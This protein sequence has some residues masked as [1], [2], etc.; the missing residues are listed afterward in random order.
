M[1]CCC[2][3]E[4]ALVDGT[5]ELINTEVGSFT[6]LLRSASTGGVPP[7]RGS[8]KAAT[9]ITTGVARVSDGA[10]SCRGVDRVGAGTVN[11]WFLLRHN[12]AN[13]GLFAGGALRGQPGR[14]VAALGKTLVSTPLTV[15]AASVACD[16]S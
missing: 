6:I 16:E 11:G 1:R 4:I 14:L 9:A 3:I 15:S 10:A 7:T 2:F 13:E 8:T 12:A 5:F